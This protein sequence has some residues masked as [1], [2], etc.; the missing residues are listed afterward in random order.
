M[1][2]APARTASTPSPLPPPSLTPGYDV[3]ASPR[4]RACSTTATTSARPPSHVYLPRR[5]RHC[6]IARSRHL[7]SV[8]RPTELPSHGPSPAPGPHPPPSPATFNTTTNVRSID[9]LTPGR[10]ERRALLGLPARIPVDRW[11]VSHPPPLR[12]ALPWLTDCPVSAE[13]TRTLPCTHKF[14]EQHT[15]HPHRRVQHRLD[16]ARLQADAR[17]RRARRHPRRRDARGAD[18]PKWV[19]VYRRREV[20]GGRARAPDAHVRAGMP[21]GPR[22]SRLSVFILG[23]WLAVIPGVRACASGPPARLSHAPRL[24]GRAAARP[25]R[26]FSWA[27]GSSWASPATSIDSVI[28]PSARIALYEA[29]FHAF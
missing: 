20:G 19:H 13:Q 24:A 9:T 1:L 21:G 18:R 16:K 26:F 22:R 27:L 17:A 12:P 8:T 7:A 2:P 23:A 25:R 4:L 3:S 15:L 11:P 5:L 29:L 28:V 6:L 14:E 10:R